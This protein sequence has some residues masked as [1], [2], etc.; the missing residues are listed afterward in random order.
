MSMMSLEIFSLC[1]GCQEAQWNLIPDTMIGGPLRLCSVLI[2][3][4][5]VISLSSYRACS[6]FKVWFVFAII[7]LRN[8]QFPVPPVARH[9]AVNVNLDRAWQNQRQTEAKSPESASKITR[10]PDPCQS[11]SLTFDLFIT[12]TTFYN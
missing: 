4:A 8:S 10:S 2:S 11:L 7:A 6:L 1:S 3:S 5:L 12:S 9:I